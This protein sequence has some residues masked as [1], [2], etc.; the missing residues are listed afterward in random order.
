MGLNDWTTFQAFSPRSLSFSCTPILARGELLHTQA[1]FRQT[2][3][4]HQ[5]ADLLIYFNVNAVLAHEGADAE[6]SDKK[7]RKGRANEQK[8]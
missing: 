2:I 1:V 4:L 8:S 3:A 7:Q 5:K 6:G